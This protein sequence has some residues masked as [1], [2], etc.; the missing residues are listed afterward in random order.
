MQN[1]NTVSSIPLYQQLANNIRNDIF[2]GK[3]KQ[4]E[5]IPSEI[6]LSEMYTISRSTVRK[7]IANLVSEGLL[8][9][10]HGKGTFVAS[11]KLKHTNN[12]FSS[13][14]SNVASMGQQLITKIISFSFEPC[15]D[16]DIKFFSISSDDT[17]LVLKRLRLVDNI[18]I[19]V[20]TVHFSNKYKFLLNDN[21][22]GSLYS[23]LQN[24]YNIIPSTGSKTI[25]I[26][27][28]TIEES[29]LLDI[30]R[31]TALMLIED[32]VFDNNSNPLHIT[33]QVIRGDKFKY[34]IK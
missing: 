4:D 6:E 10:I 3:F 8:I 22:N 17:V 25:E 21:M 23:V 5:R 20:E 28:A 14:T 13:F 19:G 16:E 7:A 26:C 12:N 9:K 1:L 2:N 29:N 31:G 33:K 30:P 11:P 34:A 18:A 24:K 32:H 27:Y 15:T